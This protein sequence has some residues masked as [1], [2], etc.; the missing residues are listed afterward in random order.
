MKG[1]VDATEI[2]PGG[3]TPSGNLPLHLE[4]SNTSSFFLPQEIIH[5][6]SGSVDHKEKPLPWRKLREGFPSLNTGK[7]G[8]QWLPKGC[9]N[10]H[11]IHLINASGCAGLSLPQGDQHKTLLVLIVSECLFV[12][13][14]LSLQNHWTAQGIE[15]LMYSSRI[16]FQDLI[17]TH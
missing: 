8:T 7:G 4:A 3:T 9:E 13:P 1:F 16:K 10:P 15:V 11:S 17:N 2:S 14:G 5:G 12:P 6:H